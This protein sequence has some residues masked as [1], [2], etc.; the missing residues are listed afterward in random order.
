M[1]VGPAGSSVIAVG[2]RALSEGGAVGGFA[3][4]Q[5]ELFCVSE[6][7]NFFLDTDEEFLYMDC[8]FGS[9]DIPHTS[10]QATRLQDSSPSWLL[11]LAQPLL[12][13]KPCSS[14]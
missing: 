6:L 3:R 5:I 1:Q 4:E 10:W 8:T 14:M 2:I 13:E 11:L 9:G 12:L 7:V